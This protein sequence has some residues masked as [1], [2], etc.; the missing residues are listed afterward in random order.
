V[1]A[2]EAI[3][4]TKSFRGVRAVDGL[5]LR[6]ETGDVVALLGPNGAGK[7]STL[8]ML[9]GITEPDAGTIDVLGHRLPQ[10]RSAALARTNFAASYMLL[11][12]EMRVRQ[13]LAVFADLHRAP[14]AK[15]RELLDMLGVGELWD[16]PTAQLS[17]GQR[18]LV[19]LAKALVNRPAL[20]VLDEPTAS[21][22]PEVADRIRGVL[23]ELHRE[24][25]FTLLITSH[26]MTEI[27]R[28][29]RRV[30]F[31]VH[32]RVVADGSP[33]DIAARYGHADLEATFVSIAQEARR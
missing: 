19:L 14:R 31:M 18:T 29:C 33:E 11:P 3:G 6:V 1:Y 16:R 25:R 8:M 9:L 13:F 26:N 30:V 24:D 5:D 28:L 21:L 4:L 22:D 20:L 2:I 12:G 10:G 17:S 32:G 23:T 7:T 27:E 15:A